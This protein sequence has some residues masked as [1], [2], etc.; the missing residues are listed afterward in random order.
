[1][2]VI[3]HHEPIDFEVLFKQAES[4][5]I[6]I[7]SRDLRTFASKTD[8][9][10]SFI[11]SAEGKDRVENAIAVA[12]GLTEAVAIIAQC[13]AFLLI[14]KYDADCKHPLTLE[15]V[16]VINNFVTKLLEGSGIKWSMMPDTTLGNKVEALLL[17][18]IKR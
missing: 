5:T 18:N 10:H 15:E 17:C 4:A 6:G 7:N 3:Q 16:S 13:K 11:G 9:I 14:I 8:E 12:I 2:N 1:M